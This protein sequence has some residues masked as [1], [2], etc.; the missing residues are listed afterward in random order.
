VDGHV[1]APLEG[2][3]NDCLYYCAKKFRLAVPISILFWEI[4]LTFEDARLAGRFPSQLVSW[5]KLKARHSQIVCA[6]YGVRASETPRV[7]E[8]K[9]TQVQLLVEVA[10]G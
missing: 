1:D 8:M 3:V 9:A 7:Q 6:F 4:S 5:R 10:G 2:Q